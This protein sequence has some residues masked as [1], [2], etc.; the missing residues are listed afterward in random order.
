MTARDRETGQDPER[1]TG[2]HRSA[3]EEE[4]GVP[5]DRGPGAHSGQE[6]QPGQRT[7]P[8]TASAAEGYS[9]GG[10]SSGEPL[11]GVERDEEEDTA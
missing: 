7:V 8:G 4:R 9:R 10:T 1:R 5:K 6:R 3:H 11:E 2:T